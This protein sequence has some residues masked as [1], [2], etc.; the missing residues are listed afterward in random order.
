[1]PTTLF[2]ARR[3]SWARFRMEDLGEF[4]NSEE[5]EGVSLRRFEGATAM[6]NKPRA[7]C[8]VVVGSFQS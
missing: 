3:G 4:C 8:Q 5:L 1:M 7:A 6:V 2:S